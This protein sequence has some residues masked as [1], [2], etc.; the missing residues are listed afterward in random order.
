MVK[1]RL[2]AY[3]TSKKYLL[4]YVFIGLVSILFEL[5]V[6]IFLSSFLKINYFYF[7]VLCSI[8]FSFYFNF[9]YNFSLR[10]ELLAKALILFFIISNI[11]YFTQMF[12]IQFDNNL[13]FQYRIL[14]SG[15]TFS[16][17][18]LIH[19]ILT[20]KEKTIIGLAIHLNNNENIEDLFNK[21]K[22]FPDFIHIDLISPDYLVGAN[23]T[24]LNL[25]EQIEHKWPKKPKQ[26]HLMSKKPL[27][28]IKKINNKQYTYFI[29]IDYLNEYI[30]V[31]DKFTDYN[32]GF[33]IL[34]DSTLAKVNQAIKLNKELLVLSIE[35]P[36]YSGQLFSEK[37][38]STIEYL[39][40]N[41]NLSKITLDGGVNIEVVKKVKLNKYVSASNILNSLHP[42]TRIYELRNANKYDS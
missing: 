34:I 3:L 20:F 13:Y 32:I 25:I 1:N 18:Y 29:D 2:V 7:G 15:A 36:G 33:T 35:K 22:N 8:A 9:K 19:K 42:V 4:A 24:E 21:V 28:Y 14:V 31:S 40:N 30:S 41:Y 27:E 37:A 6:N 16:I 38:L 11:S 23:S 39:K 26:V 17:F 5:I 10:K 12:I